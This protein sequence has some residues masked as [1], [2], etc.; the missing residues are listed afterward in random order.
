NVLV[1]DD[2]R[3]CLTD[4]GLSLIVQEFEGT[5]YLKSSVHGA[6][7]FTDP[8]LVRRANADVNVV[9]YPT[10]PSDIYSFGCLMLHILS[11]KKP[12]DG[13]R[14]IQLLTLIL[15]RNIQP[16]SIKDEQ[17]SPGHQLLIRRCWNHEEGRR[18][19]AD[20]IETLLRG[21]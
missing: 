5:S 16:P 12:Y 1:D 10:K 17:I 15:G 2:G 9:V 20:Q 18:P 7:R 4:F 19:S 3:A 21:Q 8:E 11:G 13:V 6:I 14:D